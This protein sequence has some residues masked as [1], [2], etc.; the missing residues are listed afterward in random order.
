MKKSDSGSITYSP[1]DLV[2]F[3]G[4]HHASFLDVKAL[5]GKMGPVEINAQNELLYRKGLEHEVS[6]LKMLK[7][8]CK[9][10]EIPGDYNLHERAKLTL[11]AM[12]SGVSVVYQGVLLEDSWRGD[13]DFLIKCSTPSKWGDYSYEVLDTKLA[14]TALPKH[15]TQLCVYSELLTKT[16]KAPPKKMHLFLGDGKK[17]SFN[18]SDFFYYYDRTK[19]RFEGY[20]QNLPKSSYPDPCNHCKICSWHEGCIAQWEKDNHLSLVANIQRSHAE[21]LRKADIKTVAALA[22]SKKKVKG[23]NKDIL[24][25]LKSQAALQNYK[26]ITG[27][28]KWELIPFSSGKGFN[29]IPPPD[30]GDLFFDIEGD[31]FYPD[32]LEYL[33]GVIKNENTFQPFWAHNHEEEKKAFEDFMAFVQNHLAHYPQAHIYH[34]NHYEPSAL[35][36]LACRYAICEEQ[37]DNLLRKEK[38]VDLYVVVRESMRISEPGYS[39]KNLETFYM[40]ERKDEVSTAGDSVIAYNEWQEGG[41]DAILTQ[42]ADYNK[43]DCLSTR[44]LR[45]WTIGLMPFGMAYRE[46][47][48]EE[49]EEIQ[50]KDWEI[51]YE[52]YKNRLEESQNLPPVVCQRLAHLLEFHNRENKPKWWSSFDRQNKFV[53]ELIEDTECLAGLEQT[54]GPY[55][56]KRSLIYT[57]RFPPQEYKLKAGDRPVNA[58]TMESVGTIFN[59]DEGKCLIKIK[60]GSNR[61]PLSS[62][63]S[64]GPPTPIET[65]NIRKAL[66]VYADH[67]LKSPEALHVATEILS[68]NLPR[69]KGIEAGQPLVSS[70]DFQTSLLKAVI[71]LDHSY[72]F[73]QGPPGAGKTYSSA[74]IIIEL[75]KLGKKIGIASNSHKAVNNLLEKIELVAEEKNIAPSGFK[76]SRGKDDETYFQG[77]WI[78]NKTKASEMSLDAQL[79]AGTAWTFTDPHFYGQLDYLF[80]DEAG[81]VSTANVIAMSVSSQ[82]I[83]L[84]GDQMQLGQPIQGTHPGEAGLSVLDFLLG[85]DSTISPDRGIFLGHTRRLNPSICKFISDAF[86]D[87]RLMAHESTK[88]R[89]LNLQNSG[90]PNK[91]I[92][93]IPVQHKGCSQKSIEEGRLIKEKYE[94]LLGQPFKENDGTTRSLTQNDILLVTPYNVQVNHLRSILPGAKVGTVDKFQGQE[95]PVV[96]VSMVSSSAED[97]PRNMEFLYSKNRLN[98][99][100]SRAQ[101]LAV[102]IANPNLCEAPCRTIDQMK[103]I[104]TFCW[105]DHFATK[106]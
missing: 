18:I 99:A 90:F 101:C 33:F 2:T 104:N 55:P 8:E 75:I 86:Y 9:V 102:V 73:I 57:Y 21:K 80:I 95:A 52:E 28:N 54:E 53:D 46:R 4:C 29:R 15:I 38:F 25:R 77:K 7:K 31:P 17:Y 24:L 87:G 12:E 105:L 44:L 76:K 23:L 58:E 32:G 27:E 26:A 106:V 3:L 79:F 83:I 10:V 61:E 92:V 93:M 1:S 48:I 63:L 41:N 45:D 69:I 60:L 88:E 56:E 68:K 91:G 20:V 84:V 59:I 100:L 36:R 98:V 71:N 11:E 94:G 89:R 6:Y 50:R 37:L 42:I 14:K 30:K 85:G 81:Q 47:K 64:L 39:I 62:F 65:K 66:Y 74:H 22:T 16:Q 51:E 34:Y 82:N 96:F 43:T 67:L 49:N 40:R 97:L 5:D 19:K 70:S 103:L 72:L 78:Q 13:A 35:K